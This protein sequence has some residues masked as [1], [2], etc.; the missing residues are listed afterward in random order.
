M[1]GHCPIFL[2]FY[3]SAWNYI[4]KILQSSLSIVFNTEMVG[5]LQQPSRTM[6]ILKNLIV[7]IIL[8]FQ[9]IILSTEIM[10][11]GNYIQSFAI[12]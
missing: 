5:I 6:R 12:N 4:S 2:N 3:C 11:E 10:P 9:P 7:Q 8:L 1:S